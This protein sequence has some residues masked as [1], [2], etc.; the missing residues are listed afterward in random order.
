MHR[1]LFYIRKRPKAFIT[2]TRALSKHGEGTSAVSLLEDGRVFN[3]ERDRI[4]EIIKQSKKEGYKKASE[5]RKKK[6]KG[7]DEFKET[8]KLLIKKMGLNDKTEYIE[9]FLNSE[10]DWPLLLT[11]LSNGKKVEIKCTFRKCSETAA[12]KP[13]AL[14]GH[15][16]AFHNWGIF[17]CGQCDFVTYC[18][19]GLK[20]HKVKHTTRKTTVTDF[21]CDKCNMYYKNQQSLLNH[22]SAAHRDQSNTEK[23]KKCIFCPFLHSGYSGSNRVMEN[24]Y[25]NHFE[26]KLHECEI[27]GAKFGNRFNLNQHLDQHDSIYYR[28]VSCQGD[29]IHGM[30]SMDNRTKFTGFIAD[31]KVCMRLH[32]KKHHSKEKSKRMPSWKEIKNDV[33]E[34][35]E[36]DFEE[37]EKIRIN[38]LRNNRENIM[39]ERVHERLTEIQRKTSKPIM[40]AICM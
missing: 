7:E 18:E 39:D 40:E 11:S 13:G 32:F 3:I 34:V 27:C 4:N 14:N 17:K 10:L 21:H 33:E 24:H 8:K 6:K 26:I 38:T 9:Y 28:C 2:K 19:S 1:V 30:T 20:T 23:L 5:R 16:K 37:D 29:E 12:M 22:N 25:Q 15:C 35:K 36:N 31:N